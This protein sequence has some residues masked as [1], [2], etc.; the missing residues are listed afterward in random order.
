MQKY[1]DALKGAS[2]L[3]G[4]QAISFLL[5]H[6]ATALLAY[7]VSMFDAGFSCFPD[8]DGVVW[9]HQSLRWVVW[10]TGYSDK[11]VRTARETLQDAGLIQF[12]LGAEAN[13]PTRWRIETEK[14]FRFCTFAKALRNATRPDQAGLSAWLRYAQKQPEIVKEFRCLSDSLDRYICDLEKKA[15]G[16]KPVRAKKSRPH[17]QKQDPKPQTTR[18]QTSA[19]ES[20]D[21]QIIRCPTMTFV[22]RVVTPST[23]AIAKRAF[24]PQDAESDEGFVPEESEQEQ[25]IKSDSR[26][27]DIRSRIPHKEPKAK[28][29][30]KPDRF[31]EHWNNQSHVPKCRIGTASYETARRF[32]AEYRRFMVGTGSSKFPLKKDDEKKWKRL[33][34]VNSIPSIAERRGPKKT[35]VRSDEQ[36][37][38]HIEIAARAYSPEYM[39]MGDKK[40]KVA[41]TLSSFLYSGW[42]GTY[43]KFLNYVWVNQPKRVEV[44]SEEKIR[45]QI[46]GKYD[47]VDIEVAERIVNLWEMVNDVDERD[48]RTLDDLSVKELRTALDVAKG[49]IDFH[50]ENFLTLRIYGGYEGFLSYYENT[51]MSRMWN[52][53]Y[54]TQFGVNGFVWKWF[55]DG[56]GIDF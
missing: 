34:R 42:G 13:D 10:Y 38:R 32:F 39:P 40:K 35:P 23:A 49:V 7:L 51:V 50:D 48:R 11:A 18:L 17:I 43:S 29:K 26:I 28:P 54:L 21:V 14:Y 2:F 5:G 37:F 53:V 56:L 8:E 45:K 30:P 33:A 15:Y 24:L 47:E 36:M 22:G 31:V 3:K 41:P 1:R 55:I 27:P 16:L 52:R 46:M 4:C 44:Y 12:K 25:P 20:D 9:H 6:P 19:E